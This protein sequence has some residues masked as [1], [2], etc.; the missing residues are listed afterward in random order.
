MAKLRSF[1]GE[2]TSDRLLKRRDL[3]KVRA[4]DGDA[5]TEAFTGPAA[6]RALK[7]L[8]A[9]A[10]TVDKSVILPEDFDPQR[11][12]HAALY[13][14][15]AFHAD[16]ERRGASQPASHAVHDAE[17]V[18]ARAVEGMVL[19]SMSADA[20]RGADTGAIIHRAVESGG[21]GDPAPAGG[22]GE[23]GGGGASDIY[24]Q[25]QGQGL[26]HPEIVEQL[27]RYV[28]NAMDERREMDPQRGLPS[29]PLLR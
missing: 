20:D 7:A 27:A 11:P 15:E 22:P 12:E 25:M 9:R 18:G 5:Q 24:A 28:L 13:A 6:T 10:M 3:K 17:E 1:L 16:A 8:G 2:G 21:E 14:H 23:Q 4:P 29:Q 26:S 19:H